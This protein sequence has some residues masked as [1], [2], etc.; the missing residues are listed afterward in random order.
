MHLTRKNIQPPWDLVGVVRGVFYGWWLVGIS[1]I[2]LTVMSVAV[3]QGLGTFLVT[4][5][6]EF[7]WSRTVLSGAFALAR[8]QGA[9]IGP[10]EGFLI[11]KIG[12]RRMILFGYMMMA[13]GFYLFSQVHSIWQF[14][15]AFI[16]ITLGSGLGGWLAII[17][18]INNWFSRM[19]S[20]AMATTMSGIHLGGFLVPV[21][22]LGLEIYGFRWTTFGISVFLFLLVI[23][24]YKALYNAPEDKGLLPDGDPPRPAG[25]QV[26][27]EA[28]PSQPD[29]DEPDFTARQ[30]LRTRA[31]WILTIVHMSSSISIVSLALHLVPKLTDMGMSLS[32]AGT[33]VLI[34][35]LFAL[36]TQ[37]IAGYLA[38]RLPKPPLIFFFITLQAVAILIIA[39]ANQI[40]LALVFAVLYGIGFGGRIPLLTAIRGEYFGRKA[41]ATI[42]GLSQM[43]NNIGMIFAPLFAGFMFDATGTYLV[44]F[45]IFGV[46]NL[47]GGF[48]MLTVRK[49]KLGDSRSAAPSPA[50]AD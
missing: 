29:D 4:L 21:L 12:N 7:G 19:R 1:V 18:M 13:F 20:M 33:I 25:K 35:T 44:P 30:A 26:A 38:D 22:A 32:G 16:V 17:S 41:F 36:P 42:M 15:L 45:G 49:P 34:Y 27:A 39:V 46:L 5:Q 3:F 48:L 14:Y 40:S 50:T 47:L 2:L 23:P 11:D 9:V 6:R 24:V 43:P 10:V 37:F 31:F 28:S 8:A